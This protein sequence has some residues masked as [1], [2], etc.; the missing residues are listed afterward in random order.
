MRE[1]TDADEEVVK[2]ETAEG[3]EQEQVVDGIIAQE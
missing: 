3:D 1:V 2:H